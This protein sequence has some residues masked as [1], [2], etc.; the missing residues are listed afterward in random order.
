MRR[1]GLWTILVAALCLWSGPLAPSCRAGAPRVEV[2]ATLF[3]LA[4]VARAVVGDLG[5]VVQL[6]P[7]GADPHSWAPSPSVRRRL[8]RA[9]LFL[10]VSPRLEPWAVE[11]LRSMDHP[12]PALSLAQLAGGGAGGPGADPHLW[13]D[14]ALDGALARAVARELEGRFPG[15]K[16]RFEAHLTAFLKEL[17]ALDNAFRA[18]LASCRHKTLVVAGHA[19][20]GPLAAR[21]G[22]HQVALEGSS[23]D[24]Q[25]SP[26]R[27]AR[28]VEL[29]RRQGLPAVFAME[30]EPITSGMVLARESGARLIML[31]NGAVLLP[32]EVAGRRGFLDLLKMDLRRLA[33]GLQ[34]R[35]TLPSSGTGPGRRGLA[36]G[37][38]G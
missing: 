36:P 18:T 15:L 24:A 14:L 1:R 5:Q 32:E 12:P 22:L 31:N 13:L 37:A 30:G 38:G 29:V 3:P 25:P 19:A 6:V 33:Q 26:R 4:Q 27:L 7:V 23:P 17:T 11:M 20:F 9:H 34:C 21:Y 35:L 2:V 8:A 28:L 10:F 16:G